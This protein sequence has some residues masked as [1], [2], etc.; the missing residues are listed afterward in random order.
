LEAILSFSRRI[1]AK[2]LYYHL[3]DAHRNIS[4]RRIFGALAFLVFVAFLIAGTL[5]ISV[6]VLPILETAFQFTLAISIVILSEA[7]PPEGTA[8]V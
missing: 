2:Y 7:L 5:W 4:S 1:K 6:K 3:S 8:P